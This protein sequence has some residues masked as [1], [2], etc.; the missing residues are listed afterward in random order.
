[1][2]EGYAYVSLYDIIEYTFLDPKHLPAPLLPLPTSPHSETP[3]GKELLAGFI[4]NKED[5][6]KY[7][8]Y[9][10]EIILWIDAFMPHN[11]VIKNC[12]SVHTC[13]A[14]IGRP[15][16]DCSGQFSHAV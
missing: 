3:R 11:V 12:C 8:I 16:G 1:M 6:V 7:S 15:Y 13:I 9:P 10:V 4:E 2:G 5:A 14:T